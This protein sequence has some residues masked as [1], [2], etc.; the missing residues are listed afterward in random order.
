MFWHCLSQI[1]YLVLKSLWCACL[2]KHHN[3]VMT[4][5]C[6]QGPP[7]AGCALQSGR[8]VYMTSVTCWVWPTAPA[9]PGFC[10]LNYFCIQ[11]Q[12]QCLSMPGKPRPP[13][14][15]NSIVSSVPGTSAETRVARMESEFTAQSPVEVSRCLKKSASLCEEGPL[16]GWRIWGSDSAYLRRRC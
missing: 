12:W 7:D 15:L 13:K 2:S 1:S 9:G 4:S 11:A 10:R 14:A 16:P 6:C 3:T 5:F 8:R